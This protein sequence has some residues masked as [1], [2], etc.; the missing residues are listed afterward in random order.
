MSKV[1]CDFQDKD[2]EFLEEFEKE[3]RSL[4]GMV[5]EMFVTTPAILLSPIYRE[6]MAEKARHVHRMQT[7]LVIDNPGE[8]LCKK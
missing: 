8:P 6:M 7:R 3:L 1:I 2:R 4:T 5:E